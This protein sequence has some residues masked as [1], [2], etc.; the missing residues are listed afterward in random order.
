MCRLFALRASAPC[1][2]YDPL[3]GADHSLCKQS[4]GDLKKECH[5]DGWGV[6]YYKDNSVER[7]RSTRSAALDPLYR[8]LAKSLQARTVLAHVRQASMGDVAERNCH[9]FVYGPWLFA[10]NGT[11]VGFP[12]IREE[13]RATLP[14]RLSQCIQGD[15]DSEHAFFLILAR[16]EQVMGTVDSPA[17]V[18]ALCEVMAS[19]IRCLEERSPGDGK[20]PSRFNF[21]LTDGES[22]VA[23]RFGHSLSWQKGRLD[24]ADAVFIASE[25]T[26]ADQWT[27]VPDRSLVWVDPDLNSGIWKPEM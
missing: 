20:E 1:P 13:V 8:E 9:P 27:E 24:G 15:T 17:P 22:V 12:L 21:L 7:V 11:I 3:Y 2:V 23:S 19:T 6:G 14:G 16:L 10:H 26:T 5:E 25:P 18:Q 4:C